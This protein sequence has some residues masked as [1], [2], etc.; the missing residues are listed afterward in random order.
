MSKSIQIMAFGILTIF[1]ASC[2]S[3]EEKAELF[4]F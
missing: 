2:Q 1:M 3:K 4:N